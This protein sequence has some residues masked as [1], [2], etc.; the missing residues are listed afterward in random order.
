MV[1][2]TSAGLTGRSFTYAAW[3]SLAPYTVPPRIP[4]PASTT[5]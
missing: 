2:Q 1:A 3:A 4:P 5:E